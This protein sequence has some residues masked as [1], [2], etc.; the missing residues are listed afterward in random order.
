MR[1]TRIIEHWVLACALLGIS[2]AKCTC[3]LLSQCTGL[4]PG[5]GEWTRMERASAEQFIFGKTNLFKRSDFKV[6]RNAH[7]CRA[8]F[9]VTRNANQC[10]VLKSEL[11]AFPTGFAQC[12]SNAGTCRRWG[13]AQQR[14]GALQRALGSFSAADSVDLESIGRAKSAARCGRK[15]SAQS[16]ILCTD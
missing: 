4:C 2:S 14:F 5:R 8:I 3:A 6:T 15:C 13:T 12:R 7:Q 1:W 11:E 10:R 16:A 9:K